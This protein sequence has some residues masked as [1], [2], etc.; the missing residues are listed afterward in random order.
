M[1][2]WVHARPLVCDPTTLLLLAFVFAFADFFKDREAGFF[3]VGDGDRL[4]RIKGGPNPAHRFFAGGTV[5]QWR[6]R[7]RSAQCELPAAHGAAPF[8]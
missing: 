6:R 3:G 1:L 2:L 7:E 5:G 4:R 8:A